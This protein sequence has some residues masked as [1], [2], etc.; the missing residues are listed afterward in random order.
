MSSIF[1][2]AVPHKYEGMVL[3]PEGTWWNLS[4]WRKVIRWLRVVPIAHV[5]ACV[6]AYST[7]KENRC[8]ISLNDAR[9]ILYSLYSRGLDVYWRCE[10]EEGKGGT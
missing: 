3:Y 4:L 9:K 5:K 1:E 8:D 7:Y 10:F 2:K 6:R